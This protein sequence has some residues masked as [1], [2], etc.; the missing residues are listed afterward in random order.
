MKQNV[1]IDTKDG[2]VKLQFD[3][4]IECE[5]YKFCYLDSEG[6]HHKSVPNGLSSECMSSN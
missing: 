4:C 5:S 6:N 1:I 3:K 2:K